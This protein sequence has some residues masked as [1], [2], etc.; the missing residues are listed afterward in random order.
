MVITPFK[1]T[2]FGTNRTNLAPFP[3]YGWLYVKF[4]LVTGVASLYHHHRRWFPANIA[5]SDISLKARFFGLHFT[6]IMYWCIFNHLYVIWFQKPSEFG[7]I[8]QTTRSLRR[9]RS[10]KVTDFDTNRKPI[11]DFLLVV[12]SNLPSILHRFQV[13]AE[14]ALGSWLV[15]YRNKCPAP[16]IEPG[17]GRPSQY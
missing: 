6:R 7:E 2:H 12:N 14:L 10:F 13:T 11:C 3:S 17:H 15:T 9:S 1:V 5:I 8:T 16:G 4:S